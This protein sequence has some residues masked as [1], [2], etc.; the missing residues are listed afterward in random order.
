VAG[1][2]RVPQGR[3]FTSPHVSSQN[4]PP[5]LAGPSGVPHRPISLAP[6]RIANPLGAR[7]AYPGNR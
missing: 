2:L 3:P 7:Y 5:R 4:Q 1:H 6:P